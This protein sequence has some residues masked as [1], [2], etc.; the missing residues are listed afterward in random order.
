MVEK[1]IQ[2]GFYIRKN[3]QNNEN[4]FCVSRRTAFLHLRTRF[5]LVKTVSVDLVGENSPEYSK[6][7]K[8]D[9]RSICCCQVS[10]ELG[11]S[12]SGYCFLPLFRTDTQVRCIFLI[13][14]K[15][16]KMSHRIRPWQ[17]DN[18]LQETSHI[19]LHVHLQGI[20]SEMK[21][22]FRIAMSPDMQKDA[23][24]WRAT[25]KMGINRRRTSVLARTYQ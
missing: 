24:L 6:T 25:T 7:Q 1:N 15:S 17:R 10:S 21:V 22:D 9:F 8:G 11:E 5:E 3:C 23:S 4:K 13:L 20:I 14:E 19:F 16:L 18:Q 2:R 12:I